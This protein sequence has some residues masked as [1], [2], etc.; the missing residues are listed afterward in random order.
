VSQDGH[1]QF[2]WH[3][4]GEGDAV[5]LLHGLMGDMDHWTDALGVLKDFCRPIALTLPIF[6]PFLLD[7]SPVELCGWVRAFLDAQGIA[8]AVIG[9]NSLGGHVA[10]ELALAHPDRVSGLVLTGSSGLFERSFTR[11]VPHRPTPSW[12][13]T[14]M[15]EVFYNPA[16][17]TTQ[18][19]ESVQRAV[20]TR[21]SV[22]RLLQA[23]RAAK[24]R[25]MEARLP[26][27]VAP[28]CIIWG[29]DDRITP[30]EV[31]HRFH[32]LIPRS[33]LFFLP[34][35]GHAPMLEQ[36]NAFN[37]VLASWLR[38]TGEERARL[39]VGGVQ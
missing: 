17:V 33:E 37:R 2:R 7:V 35:C 32:A 28:T 13:R 16:M 1:P 5:L 27:I 26:T 38:R 36:P 22:L 10:L 4:Q 31:A 39:V 18:W 29:A 34:C 30:P 19:V 25:N 3:E 15:E 8:R 23:A 14:K 11:G 20:T 12:V 6:E 24:H 9:G 21:S